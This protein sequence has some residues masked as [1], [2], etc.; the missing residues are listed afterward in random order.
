M[1]FAGRDKQELIARLGKET[2]GVAAIE[3]NLLGGLYDH[4]N[5]RA[6]AFVDPVSGGAGDQIHGIK[7]EPVPAKPGHQLEMVP[8][9]QL[10]L[11]IKR[12]CLKLAVAR[13]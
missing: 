10:L 9:F 12:Q 13:S 7:V 2:L 1:R 11:Q 4:A 8:D 6:D 3:R 5:P